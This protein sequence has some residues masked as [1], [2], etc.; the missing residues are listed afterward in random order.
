MRRTNLIVQ[1]PTPSQ[2][3]IT[4]QG[5]NAGFISLASASD[6]LGSY[7]AVGAT[8]P[9]D[10]SGTA[11]ASSLT[12]PSRRSLSLLTGSVAVF[13]PFVEFTNNAQLAK[14]GL[15]RACCL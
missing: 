9:R 4:S 10:S 11:P 2:S 14:F 3:S 13:Q 8:W 5:K 12:C 6:I 15:V 1:P 7:D